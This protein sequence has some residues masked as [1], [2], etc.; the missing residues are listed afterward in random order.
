ME[1]KTDLETSINPNRKSYKKNALKRELV[2]LEREILHRAIHV[3]F[4]K[5]KLL[6][7]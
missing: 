2:G 7:S 4:Q 3:H 6:K 1:E 5:R